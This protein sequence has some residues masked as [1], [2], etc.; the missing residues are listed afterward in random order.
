MLILDPKTTRQE[1]KDN[2]TESQRH[3][4]LTSQVLTTHQANLT[5]LIRVSNNRISTAPN[6]SIFT[7]HIST[8]V[9]VPPHH[10]PT[11]PLLFISL[12]IYFLSL[13]LLRNILLKKKKNWE[14]G[15]FFCFEEAISL[16][17]PSLGYYRVPFLR[18]VSDLSVPFDLFFFFL[19]IGGFDNF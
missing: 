9:I 15:E 16:K 14:A 2:W 1:E 12:F 6:G 4:S 19:M 5:S 17:K 3:I 11:P 10:L 8:L 7:V 13:P 18:W